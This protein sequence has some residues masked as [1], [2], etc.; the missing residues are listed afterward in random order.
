MA[1]LQQVHS[2]PIFK[3]KTASE[4]VYICTLIL[5]YVGQFQSTNGD[6]LKS[7][8]FKMTKSY[9]TLKGEGG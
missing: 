1:V 8:C 3:G 7:K 9:K 2:S 6:F 5:R 4:I